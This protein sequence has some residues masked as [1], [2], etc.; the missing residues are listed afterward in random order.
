MKHLFHSILV[1]VLTNACFAQQ[2][3]TFINYTQEEG[4]PSGTIRG[5]Y[6]DTA[7]YLWLTSEEG[8]ARFDGYNFKVFRHN[9][10][11]STSLSSHNCDN[12]YS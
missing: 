7:G 10:D 4:L 1:L 11:D 9:P 2:Q 5:I 6:K 3:Y 8:V 12:E